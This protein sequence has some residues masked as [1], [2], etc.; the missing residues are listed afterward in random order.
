M[1]S[2][3]SLRSF[4][5]DWG[6]RIGFGSDNGSSWGRR[7]THGE[8]ANRKVRGKPDRAKKQYHPEKKF[9]SHCPRALER[10]HKGRYVLCG[11]N[12]NEHGAKSHSHDQN[13]C[14]NGC[15]YHFHKAKFL[16][17]SSGQEKDNAI[18]VWAEDASVGG[19]QT[20]KSE[21]KEKV[22]VSRVA[23]VSQYR[24]CGDSRAGRS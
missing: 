12:Q 24:E 16:P 21:G 19:N 5:L 18:D 15:Q 2:N 8:D 22:V 9:R 11:L 6:V 20:R 4:C 1:R 10:R 3:S 13:R 14:K 23:R 7:F 17:P